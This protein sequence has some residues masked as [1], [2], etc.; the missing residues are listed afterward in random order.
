[1]PTKPMVFSA[2]DSLPVA[3]L[4]AGAFCCLSRQ[5]VPGTLSANVQ[6]VS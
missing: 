6:I 4:A 1:M 2:I 5:K 3:L